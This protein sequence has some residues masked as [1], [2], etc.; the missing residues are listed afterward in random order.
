[1]DVLYSPIAVGPFDVPAFQVLGK[2]AG[3]E[4]TVILQTLTKLEEI[5]AGSGVVFTINKPSAGQPH[6]TICI[7]GD[8]SAFAQYGSFLGL[9][10]QVDIGNEDADGGPL[11]SPSRLWGY[12]APVTTPSA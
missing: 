5:F 2:L 1:M 12:R 11:S 3:H 8:D 4:P 7:G 6:S 10:E 9:A